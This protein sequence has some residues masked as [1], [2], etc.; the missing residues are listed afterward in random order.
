[1][2]AELNSV[3]ARPSQTRRRV[4]P[5]ALPGAAISR[6]ASTGGAV[7][8]CSVMGSASWRDEPD[9]SHAATNQPVCGRRG[10]PQGPGSAIFEGPS[11]KAQVFLGTFSCP[12][13]FTRRAPTWRVHVAAPA[14]RPADIQR[15]PACQRL[16]DM[17][18]CVVDE[19]W[20]Y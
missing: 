3:K 20:N 4:G 17:A 10:Q 8:F 16:F 12:A 9:V 1:M 18:G 6:L 2:R 19:G 14:Q 5:R 7:M 11:T 15:Q 13:A